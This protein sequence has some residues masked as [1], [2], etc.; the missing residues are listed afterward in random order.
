MPV[1]SPAAV[2]DEAITGAPQ[3]IASQNRQTKTFVKRDQ[4]KQIG[5][6][7]ERN[8]ISKG[9]IRQKMNLLAQSSLIYNCLV[10]DNLEYAYDN[11]QIMGLPALTVGIGAD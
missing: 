9:Y 2:V 7:I 4:H 5:C 1:I 11:D 6:G 3:A 10:L 8:Q